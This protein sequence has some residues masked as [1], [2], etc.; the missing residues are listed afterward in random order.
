LYAIGKWVDV[1]D[2]SNWDSA[3]KNDPFNPSDYFRP[4]YPNRRYLIDHYRDPFNNNKRIEVSEYDPS[5]YVNEAQ[6]SLRETIDFNMMRPGKLKSL[7]VGNG[8]MAEVAY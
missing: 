7:Y 8:A 2:G 6:N 5:I 4:G 1:E 3:H